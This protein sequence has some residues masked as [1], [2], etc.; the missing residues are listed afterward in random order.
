MGTIPN[1]PSSMLNEFEVA[2]MLRLSVATIR[3]W[4]TLKRGPRYLKVGASVRYRT[5][6]M[7]A[8][9]ESLP[10]GGGNHAN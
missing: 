3:R 7:V 1:P 9:L 4:R 5:E 2:Q 10:T 6:D 8:W